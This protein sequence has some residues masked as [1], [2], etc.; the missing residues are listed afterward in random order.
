MFFLEDGRVFTLGAYYDGQPALG[1]THALT[2]LNDV[3]HLLSKDRIA[4][5]REVRFPFPTHQQ[6]RIIGIEVS[7]GEV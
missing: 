5:P 1:P 4:K 7:Y 3:D 6:E 2:P